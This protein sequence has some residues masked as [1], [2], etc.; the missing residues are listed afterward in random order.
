MRLPAVP[1]LLGCV[2]ASGFVL[3]VPMPSTRF[4]G[5][6]GTTAGRIRAQPRSATTAG[7]LFMAAAGDGDE[8]RPWEPFATDVAK[9]AAV[10]ATVAA[11]AFSAPGGALAA[12]SSDTISG[13]SFSD[14][15]SAWSVSPSPFFPTA[16][17]ASR[18][19]VVY[20]QKE[21]G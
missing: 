1:G 5:P 16:A 6:T 2:P 14:T 18:E 4:L 12:R 13:G 11:V 7:S 19:R 15:L 20:L 3:P 8:K 10:V 21:I 9:K 17:C